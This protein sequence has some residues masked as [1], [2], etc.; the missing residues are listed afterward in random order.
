[1]E[2]SDM[3]SEFYGAT[4]SKDKSQLGAM[5]QVYNP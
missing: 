4:F 5:V 2:A 3:N 1:M